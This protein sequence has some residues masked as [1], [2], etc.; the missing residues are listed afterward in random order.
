M[1][2]S[3]RDELQKDQMKTQLTAAVE[4]AERLQMKLHTTRKLMEDE[5]DDRI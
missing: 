3:L 4:K 2:T 5:A 1:N